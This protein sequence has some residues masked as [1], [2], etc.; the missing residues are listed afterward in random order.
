[1]VILLFSGCRIVEFI[2]CG[3]VL[4]LVV[5]KFT[6]FYGTRRLL[7]AFTR[8]HHLSLSWARLIHPVSLRPVLVLS[9]HASSLFPSRPPSPQ[10]LYA[11]LLSDSCLMHHLFQWPWLGDLDSKEVTELKFH[12]FVVICK[13]NF[14]SS[15]RLLQYL[16]FIVN[17]GTGVRVA[18]CICLP[19]CSG[20][21]LCW[22]AASGG[23]GKCLALLPASS[24]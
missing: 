14:A 8:A 24:G 12:M 23:E 5:N 7:T 3:L 13:S 18:D 4:F 11:L 15:T 1:M 2:V 9:S 17:A 10:T 16:R 6:A 22:A 21:E 20:S 19:R